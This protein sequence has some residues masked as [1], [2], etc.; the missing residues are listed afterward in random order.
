[1]WRQQL[2]QEAPRESE[3]GLISYFLQSITTYS[4]EP[5]ESGHGDISND[6]SGSDTTSRPHNRLVHQAA[7]HDNCPPGKA[8]E[9]QHHRN[10][11]EEHHDGQQT[12]VQ[13]SRLQD[14]NI[15]D[16]QEGGHGAECGN[17]GN[18]PAWKHNVDRADTAGKSEDG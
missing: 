4:W 2:L 15:R 7:E 13:V 14:G 16:G 12:K 1:M 9:D 11:Q 8:A 6:L 5:L 18:Q 17:I 3:A 10:G